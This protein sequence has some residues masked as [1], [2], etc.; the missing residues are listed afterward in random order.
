MFGCVKVELQ[1]VAS[2]SNKKIDA[3]NVNENNYVGVDNLL[4][5]KKGKTVSTHVP[6]NGMLVKFCEGDVLIGNIRP[7]LKK[8]W[9]ADI[10][11]GTNGDVLDICPIQSLVTPAYLYQILATDVFFDYDT[12]NSKGAKMPRGDKEK[13]M[14]Y[15]FYLPSIEKQNEIISILNKF[16]I[17]CNDLTNGL[18]A[19]IEA[20]NKQYVYYRNKILSFDIK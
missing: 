17:L 18:P 10:S 16:E 8:I 2:Y 1:D 15:S 7:Y 12:Q 9:L 5:N 14:K 11:G 6:K 3:K 13:V 19:E 20:R 4:Q